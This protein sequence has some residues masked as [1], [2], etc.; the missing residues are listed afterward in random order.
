MREERGRGKDR[1]EEEK[2]KKGK[3]DWEVAR[4][5]EGEGR[6]LGK[7]C[8]HK[9]S[10][11]RVSLFSNAFLRSLDKKSINQIITIDEFARA[12]GLRYQTYT[13]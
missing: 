7:G 8:V 12:R 5:L 6:G 1:R 13:R 9:G 3:D 11:A 2:K 4:D 10:G